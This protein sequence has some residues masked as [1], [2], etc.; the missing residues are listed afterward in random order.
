MSQY[1]N[2][3]EFGL[4]PAPF[5]QGSVLGHVLGVDSVQGQ[6]AALAH[7]LVHLTIPLGETPL[8][9]DIDL[10]EFRKLYYK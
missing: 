3:S 10:K 1:L 6:T 9:G 4:D 8:L 5:G 7:V 2:S